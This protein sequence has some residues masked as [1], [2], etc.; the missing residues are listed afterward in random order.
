[1]SL[2]IVLYKAS[3]QNVNS[4][5]YILFSGRFSNSDSLLIDIVHLSFI[6]YFEMLLQLLCRVT[7]SQNF[8]FVWF[9]SNTKLANLGPQ[10]A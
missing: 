5:S 6:A 3:I 4:F 2:S 1:M 7:K 10:F 8:V 9:K